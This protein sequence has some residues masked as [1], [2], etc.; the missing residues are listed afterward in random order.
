MSR[1]DTSFDNTESD[2]G[3]QQPNISF[4]PTQRPQSDNE[5][6]TLPSNNFKNCSC[7]F[8]K[9]YMFSDT[10]M[11]VKIPSKSQNISSTIKNDHVSLLPKKKA[12]I[13]FVQSI[14]NKKGVR[15]SRNWK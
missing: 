15:E 3:H 9:I 12:S 14:K 6:P 10:G 11:L 4:I 2:S 7:S 8:H 5:T 1:D 13:V